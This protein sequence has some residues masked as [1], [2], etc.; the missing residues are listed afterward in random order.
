MVIG[1]N[2]KNKDLQKYLLGGW[3]TSDPTMTWGI[4][5]ESIM[6]FSLQEGEYSGLQIDC[7]VLEGA[8]FGEVQVVINSTI[9]ISQQLTPRTLIY[10]PPIL[11]STL[12]VTISFSEIKSN[13]EVNDKRLITFYLTE[14]TLHRR[15]HDGMQIRVPQQKT[16]GSLRIRSMFYIRNKLKAIL[17]IKVKTALKALYAKFLDDA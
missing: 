7:F 5:L 2:L 9:R 15:I 6:A 11:I 1:D 3:D 13:N 14:L 10:L 8:K 16:F 4:G 17:P 12:E